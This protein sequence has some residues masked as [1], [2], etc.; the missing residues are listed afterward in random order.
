ME[1]KDPLQRFVPCWP[2]PSKEDDKRDDHT[3]SY[4]TF[5]EDMKLF[6]N[7][8]KNIIDGAPLSD[9]NSKRNSFEHE[10][11]KYARHTDEEAQ[12]TFTKDLE[13]FSKNFKQR[14][15]KL[16]FTQADVGLALG[17][18]YG[19][20]FSQTTICRFEALQLSVRNM[21]KLQPLLQKWLEETDCLK[22]PLSNIEKV[23]SQ[24]RKRKKRTSIDTS[25]K[26]ILEASFNRK[27]KPSACDLSKLSE[28]LQL[29][30]EVIRV[31][32][33]NRRQKQKRS[34]AGEYFETSSEESCAEESTTTPPCTQSLY[35]CHAPFHNGQFPTKVPSK[36]FF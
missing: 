17:T 28:Q 36:L 23:I 22:A 32:F 1:M 21:C 33:C 18:L 14:R 30:K 31:W 4:F 7:Q 10:I 9:C 35:N 24:R 16:G 34:L 26:E 25:I 29:E 19:N 12:F 20:V 8:E 3:A 6:Q 5:G 27:S 13:K 2:Y 11:L 15:I